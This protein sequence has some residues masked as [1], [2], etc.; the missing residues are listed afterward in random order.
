MFKNIEIFKSLNLIKNKLEIFVPF[1]Y[2]NIF[3]GLKFTLRQQKQTNII[4]LINP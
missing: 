4:L 3:S 1:Q 2:L